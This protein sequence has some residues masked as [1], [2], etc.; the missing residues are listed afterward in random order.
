MSLVTG[1]CLAEI[2]GDSVFGFWK[3]RGLAAGKLVA[4]HT[5]GR[6]V[7]LHQTM[8]RGGVKLVSVTRLLRWSLSQCR[9]W[10]TDFL[11]RDSA[12]YAVDSSSKGC[13]VEVKVTARRGF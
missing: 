6:A 12:S 4:R 5:V 9:R 7:L 11:V 8:C 3:G 10:G 2:K 13:F 1:D